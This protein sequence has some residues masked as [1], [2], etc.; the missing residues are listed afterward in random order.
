MFYKL[1]K[2]GSNLSISHKNKYKSV[3]SNGEYKVVLLKKVGQSVVKVQKKNIKCGVEPLNRSELHKKFQRKLVNQRYYN[4]KVERYKKDTDKTLD[5]VSKFS[6]CNSLV[7][8]FCA[9]Y[10][11]NYFQTVTI[12]KNLVSPKRESSKYNLEVDGSDKTIKLSLFKRYVNR[13]IEDLRVDGK[14]IYSHYL[15]AYERNT[16]NEWHAHIVFFVLEGALQNVSMFLKNKWS[17]G[18]SKVIKIG[19]S[20]SDKESLLK[21]IFKDIDDTNSRSFQ[22]DFFENNESLGILR[23]A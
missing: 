12:N 8:F 20:L 2:G 11:F 6:Y 22:W 16:N 21:Y 18:M 23:S 9:K 5:K 15:I 19:D 4:K 3:L 14:L 1:I 13:F 17:L 7:D 10:H